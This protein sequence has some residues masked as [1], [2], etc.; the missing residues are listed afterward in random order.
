MFE[1]QIIDGLVNILGMEV[2]VLN[3][4]IFIAQQIIFSF[5]FFCTLEGWI[6]T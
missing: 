6:A 1:I 2:L 4:E 3:P 5:Q